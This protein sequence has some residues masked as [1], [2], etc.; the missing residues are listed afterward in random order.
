MNVIIDNAR[1]IQEKSKYYTAE[2]Q[3]DYAELAEWRKAKTLLSDKYFSEMLSLCNMTK[4]Q[5]AYSV[6]NLDDEYMEGDEWYNLFCSILEEFD[7]ENID[8]K[9]GVNHVTLPFCKYFSQKVKSVVSELTKLT[10][11]ENVIEAFITSH[12]IEMFNVVGKLVAVKLATFKDA[13]SFAS[14]NQ[15]EQFEEFLEKSFYS[16]EKFYEFYAEYP[17][18]AR[19]A[20]IRTNFFVKNYSE[21]LKRI[22]KDYEEICRFLNKKDLSLTDIKLS[23]GDSHGGG[24]SVS[25][26]IFDGKKLVYKPKNLD[27]SL[28]FEEFTRWCSEKSG[29]L[30]VIIPKGIYRKDYCYNEFIES[31]YC[32]SEEQIERFYTRFGYLI[33]I[34]YLLNIN[35]L[36]LENVIACGEYPIIIDLETLFQAETQVEGDSVFWDLFN[37]LET[38][39]VANSFLL[40]RQAHIGLSDTVDLSALNGRETE[41]ETKILVPKNVNTSD[42]H[43]EK[44]ASKFLGG[45]NIPQIGEKSEADVKRYNFYIYEGFTEFIEFVFC[46]KAECIEKI[47]IFKGNKI[48][49]LAKSTE[50]YASMIRYA[51][52]PNYNRKMKYRERLMMN[53]WAYPYRDKRIVKSEI[54]DMLFNDIP[55]F[56]SYV[57]SRDLIDSQGNIYKDYHNKSGYDL[58]VE[59]ISSLTEEEILRQQG[60]LLLALDIPN[61]YLNMKVARRCLLK[62][63]RKVD[64]F[65]QAEKIIHQLSSEQ[66]IRKDRCS[67]INLDCDS[68][69]KW[70]L[71]PMDASLYGG[72]SGVAIL[73]L[74]MYICTGDGLYL[75]KYKETINTAIEQTKN[76]MFESAFTGWLSPIYPM[77]LEKR[78]LG[79]IENEDFIRFSSEK[80]RGLSDEDITGI[81]GNDYISGL[82][83]ILR[84]FVLMEEVLGDEYVDRTLIDKFGRELL[85]RIKNPD[86]FNK[87]GIAHGISGIVY[88]LFSSKVISNE[89]AKK[90]LKKEMQISVKNKDN[91]KWCWG[92]SGMI[93]ARL[94]LRKIEEKCVDDSEIAG[95][96]EKFEKLLDK[97][98]SNDTL[99][100]GNG[101]VITTMKM[102]YEYSGESKWLKKMEEWLS[103]IYSKSL[104][105]G[106]DLPHIAGITSKGLF[107]GYVGIAWMYMYLAKHIDNVLLLEVN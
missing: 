20:T 81:K 19:V 104:Y 87:A 56:F 68:E 14:E 9:A 86:V 67:F 58:A 37:Y 10:V 94:A 102:I 12:A 11:A 107:D 77:I 52:H 70:K 62:N 8:Y 13:Y 24:N 92:L 2:K 100:H 71:I 3:V 6:Q 51:N 33:A 18:A 101:S 25:V 50:K 15:N 93:Q 35:D 40:P 28:A 17:V 78:Y 48:R 99:C 84:L 54:G 88:G 95:L 46:N 16:K 69:K 22:D 75:G 57:D 60:I 30:D 76:T 91:Y 90:M 21:L 83:G 45:K 7:Y 27:I 55:I 80:L 82:A 29:L 44:E 41:V 49:F 43:Y 47:S 103:D 89:L 59:K 42:F 34:C 64:C 5:F 26:L 31:A 1:T 105:E 65:R 66:Y 74:Q 106:Y 4:E 79:T 61:P 98:V 53:V 72:L 32:T 36:H 39:S 38:K 73:F 97:T 23:S 85:K 63:T 96:I